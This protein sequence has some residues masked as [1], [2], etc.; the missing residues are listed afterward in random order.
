MPPPGCRP[1]RT[2]ERNG[3][4]WW[5]TCPLCADIRALTA[6]GEIAAAHD[7]IHGWLHHSLRGTLRDLDQRAFRES[8]PRPDK[9]FLTTWGTVAGEAPAPPAPPPTA[10]A[11]PAATAAPTAPE[12]PS[13]VPSSAQSTHAPRRPGLARWS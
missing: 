11:A 9:A 7:R 3:A 6:W 5:T 2:Y 10:Q 13:P 12:E 4:V 8:W 1:D